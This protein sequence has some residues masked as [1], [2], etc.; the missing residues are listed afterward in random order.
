MAEPSA[1]LVQRA[2]AGD[3]DA[4]AELV[5]SQ[6][7]YV[8]SIAMSLMRNPADAADMTQEAFIR[9]MR[10][11][12]TYRGETKFTTW[13]YRLVTNICLDGLRRRGRP[14]DPLDEHGGSGGDESLAPSERLADTDRWS[15][16][17]LDVELRESAGEV[18]AALHRLPA[19]QRVAL[20]LH[21]FD[22]LRYEDIADVMGLPLNTVKS[23]IRRGK[24]RLALL[25]SAPEEQRCSA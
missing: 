18:R 4:L 11:L 6:Q 15:Q 12:A 8:Y 13:L 24:E 17:E 7:T 3:R 10:S 1:A 19:Q 22:D 16:P 5:G 20:T 21:Y 14:I 9:V 25:L 2:Q 23:H